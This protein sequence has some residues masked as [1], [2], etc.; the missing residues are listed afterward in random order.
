MDIKHLIIC[1]FAAAAV[2]TGC[3]EKDKPE[4][5]EPEPTYGYGLDVA[6]PHW[7]EL[8]GTRANDGKEWFAH[9]MDGGDYFKK[10]GASRNWSFYYDYK[11]YLASWVAY[12]LNS[13][14]IGS[15]S[16]TDAWA[17][18]PLIPQLLQPSVVLASYGV[19]GYTRGHQIPSADRLR[20]A[21]NATTFYATNMT[22]QDY[23]F[24]SGIWEKVEE[25]VRKYAR[26]CDTLYVVTGCVVK[27]NAVTIADRNN[28][29][30]KIPEAYYKALLAY[31]KG[32]SGGDYVAAGFYVP[33]Q[34]SIDKNTSM[35]YIMSIAELEQKTGMDFFVNLPDVVG[36]STASDIEHQKPGSWWN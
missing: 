20:Y 34:G 16:R 29:P 33:H 24:N 5:P 26:A 1:F 11:S 22:P 12:P 18:D 30:C 13:G 6:T 21:P 35:D 17:F 23:D 3:H 14:L 36:A 9:D 25:R 19:S 27:S 28:H 7:L 31:K 15:G 32:M 8:P 4:E 2:I 10:D